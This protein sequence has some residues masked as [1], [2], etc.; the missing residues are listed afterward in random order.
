MEM[1]YTD[2]ISVRA[3]LGLPPSN[4]TISELHTAKS[5]L[6]KVRDT[7]LNDV[8]AALVPD[9]RTAHA[10]WTL[11]SSIFFEPYWQR[12]WIMQVSNAQSLSETFNGVL[13]LVLMI[14]AQQ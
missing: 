10:L 8:V 11:A 2:T 5:W 14:D 6:D 12:L 7:K 3:F 9:S 13:D 1:I 4:A